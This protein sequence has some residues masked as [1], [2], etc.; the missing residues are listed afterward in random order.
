MAESDDLGGHCCVRLNRKK[1]TEHH[2]NNSDD[3]EVL[4][5]HTLGPGLYDW[6]EAG[7]ALGPGSNDRISSLRPV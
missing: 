2:F 6:L 7:N 5:K 1:R 3:D 4:S